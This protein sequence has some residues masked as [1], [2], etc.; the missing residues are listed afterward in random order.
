M[1]YTCRQATETLS[2]DQATALLADTDKSVEAVLHQLAPYLPVR[3]PLKALDLGCAQGRTLI[4]LAQRG[5]EAYGV[6]PWDQA[7]EIGVELAAKENVKTIVR[8]GRAEAI[9]F[10]D[11]FFDIVLAFSVMEHVSSLQASLHEVYRVL[12]PGGV[13][14]FSSASAMSPIQ[15]EI[16]GFPLFSWYPDGLKQ[17]I[18]R[19][20]PKHRPELVGFTE[21]PAIHW[22]TPWKAQ[23]ELRRA[24]FAEVWD[25]WELQRRIPRSAS[26][27]KKCGIP[28]A[29]K[30]L[31]FRL[32]GDIALPHCR[33]AAR[34]AGYT[35]N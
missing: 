4:A 14:Y 34:K 26:I 23:R 17:R 28:L 31:F 1:G 22:W 25:R 21:H 30:S 7:R 20:V 11:D 5:Y 32:L 9:P 16:D 6:E 12:R 8:A 33:Y 13:F 15:N 3:R 35:H 2:L 19:W 24:G 29:K 10:D 18:M 27:L